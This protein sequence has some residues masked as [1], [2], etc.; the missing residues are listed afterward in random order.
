MLRIPTIG[1]RGLVNG[2]MRG[3]GTFSP[4]QL[5]NL[6]LWLDASKITGLADGDAVATWTDAGPLGKNATEATAEKRPTY[7]T[8]IVNGLPVVRF[9]GAHALAT[10]AIDFTAYNAV[11]LFAVATI[12]AGSDTQIILEAGT[13]AANGWFS[14]NIFPTNELAAGGVGNVGSAIFKTTNAVTG[15]WNCLSGVVDFSLSTNEAT[16]WV[17]GVSAGSRPSNNNNTG[18]LASKAIYIGAR[19][20]GSLYLTGDIAEIIIYR[21]ALSTA[22]RV[23][24]QTYLNA[25]FNLGF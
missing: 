17:N 1:R 2:L 16:G 5:P 18:M 10:A 3:G 9:G 20:H 6:A 23:R 25:K 15:T 11:T 21:G 19:N 13:G 7:K 22:D 12:T 8:N 14:L 24:V 4:S